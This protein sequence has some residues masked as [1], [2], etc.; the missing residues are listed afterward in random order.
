MNRRQFFL[1]TSTLAAS[2][3]AA[4]L[5]YHALNRPQSV[6][7][8]KI[9]LPLAHLLR[10]KKLSLHCTREHTCETLILGS[11]SA[12]L[13]AAWYLTRNGYRNFC[14]ADGFE[15][16]GNNAAFVSGSL[17]APSG[18]HYLAQPSAESQHV[19]QLLSDLDILQDYD[20]QGNPVYSETDLVF[21]PD[22]RVWFNRA[23]H[24]GQLPQY[25]A[26]TR[27]FFQ[28]ISRLLHMRGS[29]G[30]KIFA[31]PIV[32]SSRDTTWR[33]WDTITFAQWLRQ[34]HYRSPVLWWYLDYCCRDDYGQGVDVVSA[35]AG[36]HYFAARGNENAAVLTW[37]DGLNHISQAMRQYAKIHDATSFPDAHDWVFRQPVSFPAVALSIAENADDVTVILRHTHT[38]DM[39]QIR[40]KNVICAMP[41]MVAKHIVKQPEHYGFSDLRLPEYA[42]W[43]VSNFVLHTFPNEQQHSELAWDNIVYGSSG[44]GYVVATHQQ[45]RVA[46]PERTIFTAYTTLHHD[47]PQKV[48]QWLLDAQIDDLLPLAAQDLLTVYGKRLWRHVSHVDIVVRAHAMSSPSVGYLDAPLLQ[49]L[50]SHRSRI[51]FAHSDLSGYSVFEEAMYWGVQ[52]AQHILEAA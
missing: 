52:A 45:I 17:N 19:R 36:L 7:L 48:R 18:A 15:R 6:T 41:L 25:D 35:F 10:D 2:A 31:I 49:K 9:G 5:G 14:L 34:N 23:W 21:A 51:V 50:R 40:A 47:T 26:D 1:Y 4:Y 38:G 39:R 37:E 32:Q 12:A 3:S 46:K 33:Q 11:G 29:D 43:L 42:P 30:R 13:A 27:R 22:E 20:K 44:L 8:H 24:A 28:L 16:N